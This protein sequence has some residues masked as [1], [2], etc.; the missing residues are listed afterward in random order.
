MFFSL[1]QIRSMYFISKINCQFVIYSLVNL[2][3]R[4]RQKAVRFL[5]RI[6]YSGFYCFF[7]LDSIK[8]LLRE[9]E[10]KKPWCRT[11]FLT[12]KIFDNFYC[13][14]ILL[15][16]L[17]SK[18]NGVLLYDKLIVIDYQKKLF[19]LQISHNNQLAPSSNQN[20]G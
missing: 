8:W 12:N 14:N 18:L 4:L 7:R 2:I 6:F 17:T 15:C 9:K 20:S 3:Q 1:K 10:K 5:P 16:E 13:L 11:I 19:C